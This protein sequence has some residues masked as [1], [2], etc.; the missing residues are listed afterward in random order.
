[1]VVRQVNVM[2]THVTVSRLGEVE[3]S[4][5]LF[6]TVSAEEFEWELKDIPGG[7]GP[8][9]LHLTM[10]KTGKS[11]GSGP[12]WP[13]LLKKG[14]EVDMA[15][16]KRVEKDLDELLSDLQKTTGTHPMDGMEYARSMRESLENEK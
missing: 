7:G 4:G 14:P 9:E 6:G 3:L 16:V 2:P 10:T 15:G 5:E 1:L 11:A 13:Q 8:R 12:L